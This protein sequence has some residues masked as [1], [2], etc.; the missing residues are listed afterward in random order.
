MTRPMSRD[1]LEQLIRSYA[2]AMRESVIR[3]YGGPAS[4][5]GECYAKDR[6]EI[7]TPDGPCSIE[8]YATGSCDSGHFLGTGGA[9]I[10]ARCSVCG[11]WCCSTPGCMFT[12]DNGQAVCGRHA[13]E[14]DDRVYSSRSV[15]GVVAK[16]CL[17][18]VGRWVGSWIGTVART[19]GLL[20]DKKK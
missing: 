18:A 14:I 16:K 10:A 13:V 2:P 12:A 11:R 20:P 1:E 6:I 8:F 4:A 5:T 15:P 19:Y 3:I 7:D 17:G 9:E